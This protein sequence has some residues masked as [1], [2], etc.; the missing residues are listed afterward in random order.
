MMDQVRQRAKRMSYEDV[1]IIVLHQQDT[2]PISQV[3]WQ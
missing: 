1:G 2:L 3:G